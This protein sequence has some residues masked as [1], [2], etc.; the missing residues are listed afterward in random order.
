MPI[1]VPYN[2][3]VYSKDE[4]DAL[5]GV[6]ADK[7][8]GAVGNNIAGLTASQGN[9]LDTGFDICDLSIGAVIDA[10]TF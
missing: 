7:V 2:E 8:P 6:K 1:E 4:I 10:G 3:F 9:L 5:L